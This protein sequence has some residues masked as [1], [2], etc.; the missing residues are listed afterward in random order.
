MKTIRRRKKFLAFNNSFIEL[1][2]IIE[3]GEKYL[4]II[5]DKADIDGQLTVKHSYGLEYPACSPHALKELN[6][7]AAILK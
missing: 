2:M 4:V 5:L 6:V 3:K 1:K 7:L